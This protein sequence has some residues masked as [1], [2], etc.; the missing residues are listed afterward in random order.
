MDNTELFE[1]IW[2]KTLS[3]LR[4]K[5]M[6]SLNIYDRVFVN[7]GGDHLKTQKEELNTEF[8]RNFMF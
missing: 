1:I 2:E 3:D 6:K 7:M 4:H 5:I 8:N